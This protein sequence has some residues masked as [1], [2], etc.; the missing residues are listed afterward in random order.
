MNW[1]ELIG[2]M[3]ATGFYDISKAGIYPWSSA[4]AQVT[5]SFSLSLSICGSPGRLGRG[6]SYLPCK[7]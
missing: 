4:S 2:A 1:M 6:K 7:L 3:T 5:T